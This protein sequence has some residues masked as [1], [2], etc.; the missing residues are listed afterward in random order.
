[1]SG[2]PPT[3]THRNPLDRY[4]SIGIILAGGGA[5][6]AYQAGAL[7]AIHDFI[8]KYKAHD[9]VRMIAGTSIGSWNAM[10]WL[11]DLMD[12][13]GHGN[14]LEEWWS[15]LSLLGLIRP[16]LYV[17]GLRNYFLSPKPWWRSFE[18]LFMVDA[19]ASAKLKQHIEEP[20]A[21]GS[22]HFYFTRSNVQRARLEVTTN[23]CDL[24]SLPPNLPA[25]AW[26]PGARRVEGDVAKNISDLRDAV[27]SSMDLPPL[28]RYTRLKDQYYEDG[29]VIEN[30]PIQFGT[31]AE[32]CD[33]LFIL[34]LNATFSREVSQRSIV[35]RLW[36]VM[37]VRQGVLERN[38]FKMIYLYNDLAEL[39]RKTQELE[40][41]ANRA[42]QALEQSE[43]PAFRHLLGELTG[44]R[45][46]V[47]EPKPGEEASAA[48]RALMR[49][50]QR[51]QVFAICPAPRLAVNTTEFWK[52]A[53]AG[54]A[55]RLMREAASMELEKFFASPPEW[56]RMALV[57]PNREVVYL[58]EF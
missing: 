40:N 56:I 29:G 7:K 34:P 17:P 55:F 46:R 36:R 28:F 16:T 58:E 31:E 52:R 50:H 3:T 13:A 32:H 35:K 19:A 2:P 39:R 30:L 43:N 4:R 10:F 1:M 11:A 14:S 12:S 49:R 33:L 25:R 26:T 20:D 41:L 51:V 37:D 15:N 44:M 21:P 18:T 42:Y 23:R 24:A 8:G 54:R 5:K 22:M 27:F 53:A 45:D 57:Q 9:K 47:I 48:E 38:S 6:G